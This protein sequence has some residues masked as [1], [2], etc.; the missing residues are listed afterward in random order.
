MIVDAFGPRGT[1]FPDSVVT[2]RGPEVLYA[3]MVANFFDIIVMSAPLSI[4]AV[5]KVDLHPCFRIVM[6]PCITRAPLALIEVVSFGWS[7]KAREVASNLA[8]RADAIRASFLA[9]LCFAQF[10]RRMATSLSWSNGAV[11]H[12]ACCTARD[13]EFGCAG[14]REKPCAFFG[15]RPCVLL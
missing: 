12:K 2:V 1:V 9:S 5:A 6:V 11:A 4:R 13:W 3:E 7:T 15:I 14:I 10:A 8:M